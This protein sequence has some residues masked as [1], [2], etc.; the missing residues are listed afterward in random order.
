M[1]SQQHLFPIRRDKV[2]LHK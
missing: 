2:F 1:K